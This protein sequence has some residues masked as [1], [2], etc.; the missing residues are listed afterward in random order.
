MEYKGI[1]IDVWNCNQRL[2]I[3]DNPYA[4]LHDGDVCYMQNRKIEK[5]SK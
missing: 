5:E 1:Y 2:L 3:D 4:I